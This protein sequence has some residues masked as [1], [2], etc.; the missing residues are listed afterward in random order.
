VE[1]AEGFD[2]GGLTG[3]RAVAILTN[4]VTMAVAAADNC[5]ADVDR[6]SI[7]GLFFASDIALQKNSFNCNSRRTGSSKNRRQALQTLRSDHRH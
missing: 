6:Q 7:D 3:E 2:I 5:L 4:S 1:N